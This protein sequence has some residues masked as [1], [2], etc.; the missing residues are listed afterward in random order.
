M[1]YKFP[2]QAACEDEISSKSLDESGPL[3]GLFVEAMDL[4]VEV[5]RQGAHLSQSSG[6]LSK[7]KTEKFGRDAKPVRVYSSVPQPCM[8]SQSPFTLGL[9]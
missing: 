4:F 9:G 1:I 6:S 7:E 3:V 2:S 5:L 8:A